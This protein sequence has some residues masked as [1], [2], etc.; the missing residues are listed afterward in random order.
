[1]MPVRSKRSEQLKLSMSDS[2]EICVLL[3]VQ[4]GEPFGSTQA[5]HKGIR[6]AGLVPKNSK[7]WGPG[8]YSE[9]DVA[10]IFSGVIGAPTIGRVTTAVHALENAIIDAS[11]VKHLEQYSEK[12]R[13]L[14]LAPPDIAQE[15]DSFTVVLAKL[16][17]IARDDPGDFEKM[18]E[19]TRIEIDRHTYEAMIE[20]DI[21]PMNCPPNFINCTLNFSADSPHSTPTEVRIRAKFSAKLLAQ[22]AR[23]IWWRQ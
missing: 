14:A 17:S 22:A 7:H 18:F 11:S 23:R 20:L 6:A 10:R 13:D 15:G 8:Q 12:L 1:M 4:T 2:D 21:E 3:S 9:F 5:R 19:G 16:L